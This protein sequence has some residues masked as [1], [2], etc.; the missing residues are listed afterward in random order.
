M[1]VGFSHSA[2]EWNA[3]TITKV[4]QCFEEQ[5][6]VP[7]CIC[8]QRKGCIST[9]TQR[10]ESKEVPCNVLQEFNREV[11]MQILEFEQ[12]YRSQCGKG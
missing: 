11:L 6:I 2:D 1:A 3:P 4:I 8:I 5:G 10:G 12:F 9:V 7:N